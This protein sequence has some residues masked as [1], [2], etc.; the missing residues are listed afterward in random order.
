MAT[1]TGG[2][3]VGPNVE[4]D[5]ASFDSRSLRSGQLFVP[6][7]ADRDGHEFIDA[8]VRAGAPAYLSAGPVADGATAIVVEDT[9][10]ALL[11]LAR[12]ARGRFHG[13]VVGITGSVGKTT[14]KELVAAAVGTGARVWANE[15]SFNNE[16]GLPVTILGM[17]S[18]TEVLV[19]EMGM[20]GP[21]E[22]AKLCDVG[23]P[24]IGVVT[25]VA[26]AHTGRLGG[27]DGVAAAKGELVAALAPDGTAI[28]NA[29]DD[30]VAAMAGRT[31][32]AVLTFG[33]RAGS[34]VRVGAVRLDG[35]GRAH[36]TVESPWGVTPVGLGVLGAFQ[37]LNA[38]AA[39]AVAGVCGV[40]IS[41]AAAALETVSGPTQR[42]QRGVTGDGG[43]L[44]DDSYNANPTSMAAALAT[45]ASLPAARRVAVVG[46]M[47]E[48]NDPEA[49]HRAITEQARQLGIELV[50]VGTDLYG[51]DPVGLDDVVAAVG[52]TPPG[53]AVLVKASRA[54]ELERVVTLLTRDQSKDE[55]SDGR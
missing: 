46:V 7:V 53:T 16:Q 29:D 10:A 43:V 49:G 3:L 1:A 40:P 19:L 34:D 6:V 48:L 47:A 31:D 41:A 27:I 12:W 55:R 11:D 23:R 33:T 9:A 35:A 15:K 20:R 17:P 45:L 8:A 14:T 18:D 28:L 52:P 4:L 54:A 2:R 32:A 42:L 44:L 30:R 5:G 22:I 36:F 25:V 21:G 24:D 50:A 26:D 39:L 38:A 51:I 37:A 13:R